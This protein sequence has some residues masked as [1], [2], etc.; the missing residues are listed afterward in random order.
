MPA[1][2]CSRGST[3]W[4][5]P[6]RPTWREPEREEALRQAHTLVGTLGT[7]GRPEA[8]DAARIAETALEAGDC[9]AVSAAVVT[10]RAAVEAD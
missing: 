5:P 2:D 4:R 1:R 9:A 3:R 8:S 10:L 7:F 6:W